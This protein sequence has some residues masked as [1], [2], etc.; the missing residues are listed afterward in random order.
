MQRMRRGRG[1]WGSSALILMLQATALTSILGQSEGA[2]PPF[3]LERF[4]LSPPHHQLRPQFDCGSGKSRFLLCTALASSPD[5]PQEIGAGQCPQRR[6]L[7]TMLPKDNDSADML[8]GKVGGLH[9]SQSPQIGAMRSAMASILETSKGQTTK[10][11]VN[12]SVKPPKG[13]TE[14]HVVGSWNNWAQEHAMMPSQNED[15]NTPAF[16]LVLD[17]PIGEYFFKF[18]YRIPGQTVGW[19]LSQDLPI[20]KDAHG[21]DNNVVTVDHS[22]F[23]TSAPTRKPSAD[24]D[25]SH[26]LPPD[27]SAPLQYQEASTE[28]VLAEEVVLSDVDGWDVKQV[29]SF[30]LLR[31]LPAL[32]VAAVGLMGLSRL[33]MGVLGL[34]SPDVLTPPIDLNESAPAVGESSEMV[35]PLLV[36]VMLGTCLQM[37]LL[38]LMTNPLTAVFGGG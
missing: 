31:F 29:G 13:A 20:G 33:L 2:L 19:M 34:S 18:R 23:V 14:A 21:N 37:S 26:M 27:D 17:L 30:L 8:Q 1:L 32:L 16:A 10:M 3:Y 6:S 15:G 12:F 9:E 24:G 22:L 11:P 25:L 5:R 7:V 4:S 35:N 38:K 36:G 28:S